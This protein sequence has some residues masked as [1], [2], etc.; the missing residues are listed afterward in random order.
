M[1]DLKILEIRIIVVMWWIRPIVKQLCCH[2]CSGE[3]ALADW[4]GCSRNAITVLWC[5]RWPWRSVGASSSRTNF[6]TGMHC[7]KSVADRFSR[8]CM[9]SNTPNSVQ[10]LKKIVFWTLSCQHILLHQI[11]KILIFK[12][13]SYDP[14]K[15]NVYSSSDH[16][17]WEELDEK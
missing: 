9:K 8:R 14:F 2:R 17:V 12:K 13:S 5:H 11:H 10:Y 7:F 1:F 6:L 3:T 4:A 16:L 15:M